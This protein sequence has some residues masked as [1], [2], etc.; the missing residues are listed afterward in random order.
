MPHMKLLM[1]RALTGFPPLPPC[2]FGSC[3]RLRVSHAPIG[4]L[5][6]LV[7]GSGGFFIEARVRV[8]TGRDH[9]QGFRLFLGGGAPDES[10]Y[11]Q[12]LPGRQ[13]C[14]AVHVGMLALGHTAQGG[15]ADAAPLRHL[16]PGTLAGLPLCVQSGEEGVAIEPRSLAAFAIAILKA[17]ISLWRTNPSFDYSNDKLMMQYRRR[18]RGEDGIDRVWTT[19]DPAPGVSQSKLEFAFHLRQ[20]CCRLNCDSKSQT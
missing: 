20:L 8:E 6:H 3:C 11:G 16:L 10:V 13:R 17:L 19:N 18:P 2:G 4:C 12:L 1:F 5:D 14:K 9:R 7:Q 15:G